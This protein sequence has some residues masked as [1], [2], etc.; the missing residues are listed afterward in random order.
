MKHY[1]YIII[2]SGPAAYKALPSLQ[3]DGKHTLIVDGGTFGGVCPNYGCEPKIFLEGTV[4]AVLS[5]RKLLGL[6]VA[7]PA[8]IDWTQLIRRK[9]TIF[10]P[11]PAGAIK[12]YEALGAEAV[13]GTATFIEPHILE[14]NGD[15]YQADTIIIATGQR[16]NKLPIEGS[17]LTLNSDNVFDM[18]Q[19]PTHITFIGGGFVSMELATMLAAAGAK[20]DIV[21]F[22]DRPLKAF[23]A[24][25]VPIVMKELEAQGVTFH[26]NQAVTKVEK[27]GDQYKV[28]TKQ[29]LVIKTDAVVDTSGRVPNIE[30]LNL[31]AVGITHDR[32]GI[33]VDG[34]LQTNLQGVYA[35]GD[36]VS[37]TAPKLTSTAQFEGEYLGAYLSGDRADELQYPP[38]ATAAFAFP[39][40]AQ[41]G[42][43]LDEARKD[44]R[45]R[46]SDYD[47]AQAEH[48][49]AG[50]ND[51]DAKLSLIFDEADRL[52]GA[53]EVS[54]TA[55]DDI[56]NFI[57]IIGLELPKD[58]WRRQFIPVF[59]ALSYK[60]RD[61]IGEN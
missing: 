15:R 21:E 10:K 40:I 14:I 31:D 9:K 1:D 36:V 51:M 59:P 24:E 23:S 30:Q 55:A 37:K 22:A 35:L 11:F 18:E 8:T 32:G 7:T 12:A 58:A 56:D 61:M 49:Y 3:R 6:G 57:D 50:M 17:E 2:G 27:V 26:L 41:A 34:H 47:L 53:A 52:V 19:L 28:N 29:G 60:T 46:I 20:V 25:H 5:S 16:P 13:Q 33:V 39:Q 48:M 43:R 4:K 42:V 54:Q 38:I 44:S 45:Y